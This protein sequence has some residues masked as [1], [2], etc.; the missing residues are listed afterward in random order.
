MNHEPEILGIGIVLMMKVLQA[1]TE[2]QV[3]RSKSISWVGNEFVISY[4]IHVNI[5]SWFIFEQ[6]VLSKKLK[7]T[8]FSKLGYC[9]GSTSCL[10]YETVLS[11]TPCTFTRVK[12]VLLCQI[13]PLHWTFAVDSFIFCQHNH[14]FCVPPNIT[15]C[16]ILWIS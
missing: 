4:I 5:H 7:F 1:I 6:I 8:M 9:N 15:Y 10:F 13:K 14:H 3:L 2:L 12:M 16:R 11:H